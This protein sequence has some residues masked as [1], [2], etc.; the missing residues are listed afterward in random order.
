MRDPRANIDQSL[1]VLKHAKKVKP[2]VL[3]KTS[4]ML[5]LGETDEQILNTLIGVYTQRH[6]NIITVKLFPD[7][8]LLVMLQS[9][10]RQEWTV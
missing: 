4:I 8:T 3:T 1:S 9:C 5:G 2:T 6:I 10:G 7:H